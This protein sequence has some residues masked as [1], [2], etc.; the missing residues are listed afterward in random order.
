MFMF[1]VTVDPEVIDS[2]RDGLFLS[3]KA[4]QNKTKLKTL[5]LFQVVYSHIKRRRFPNFFLYFCGF[6]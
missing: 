4:K 3:L 6:W 2:L 5:S 1:R